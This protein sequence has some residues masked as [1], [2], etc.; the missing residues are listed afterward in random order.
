M[1]GKLAS[2]DAYTC[3][4]PEAEPDPRNLNQGLPLESL[5]EAIVYVHRDV[6][7]SAQSSTRKDD[8]QPTEL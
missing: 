2:I 4:L 7:P 1:S 6:K 8:R 3:L 5:F